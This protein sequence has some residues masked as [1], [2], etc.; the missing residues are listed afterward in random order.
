M[1]SMHQLYGEVVG[2]GRERER[3]REMERKRCVHKES[4]R[5]SQE[6]DVQRLDKVKV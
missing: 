2:G 3:E 6:R 5:Q 4:L 1:E